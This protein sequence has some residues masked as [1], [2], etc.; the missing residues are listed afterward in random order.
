MESHLLE[1]SNSEVITVNSSPYAVPVY[2]RLGFVETE[3]VQFSDGMRY[4]DPQKMLTAGGDDYSHSANW[5]DEQETL[6]VNMRCL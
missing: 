1:N 4:K 6:N 2:H 3:T 5:A